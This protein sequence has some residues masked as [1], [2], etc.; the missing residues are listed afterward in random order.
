[1]FSLSKSKFHFHRR[2]QSGVLKRKE[3]EE[4]CEARTPL[5][6][7]WESKHCS[8]KTEES[9]FCFISQDEEFDDPS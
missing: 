3:Q 9:H 4:F 1:M 6:S 7:A 8:R 2:N 5:G